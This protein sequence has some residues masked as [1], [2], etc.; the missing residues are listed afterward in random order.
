MLSSS[1]VQ[2]EIRIRVGSCVSHKVLKDI[3]VVLDDGINF[4]TGITDS[5]GIVVFDIDPSDFPVDQEMT[6]LQ[7]AAVG[8]PEYVTHNLAAHAS[9]H[10][11]TVI[12]LRSDY[13]LPQKKILRVAL[14]GS[15]SEN[16]FQVRVMPRDN[17]HKTSMISAQ[18]GGR[19]DFPGLGYIQVDPG[20]LSQ[21]AIIRVKPFLPAAYSPLLIASEDEQLRYQVWLEAIDSNGDILTNVLPT[22]EIGITLVVKLFDKLVELPDYEYEWIAFSFDEK[23]IEQGEETATYSKGE[24][25]FSVKDGFNLVGVG[26]RCLGIYLEPSLRCGTWGDW[27]FGFLSRGKKSK[28]LNA[29]NFICGNFSEGGSATTSLGES[30]STV[31]EL[32][33]TVSAEVGASASVLGIG[34]AAAAGVSVSVSSSTRT[35]TAIQLEQTLS[36]N[37]GPINGAVTVSSPWSCLAGT[38]QFF[39]VIEKFDVYA[40]RHRICADPE[41]ESY[42]IKYVGIMSVMH[43]LDSAWTA[44]GCRSV[45]CPT[46]PDL[47]M[48][49]LPPGVFGPPGPY[50]SWLEFLN[51]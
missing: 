5:D 1:L 48:K 23:F 2:G 35:T 27:Q 8:T 49:P 37:I 24:L 26:G 15:V 25:S 40:Y 16:L 30:I 36:R 51:D 42:Q 33:S 18:K 13:I 4:L 11:R 31:N 6:D 44:A 12:T 38:Y 28:P 46:E 41:A 32:D 7:Q 34:L 43:G 17:G 19:F 50:S 14:N 20:A 22:T 21:D 45:C 3:E 9:E 10:R 47:P 29:I 39:Q